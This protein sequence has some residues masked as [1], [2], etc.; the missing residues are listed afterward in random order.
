[1]TTYPTQTDLGLY[2]GLHSNRWETTHLSHGSAPR[3]VTRL[4]HVAHT[5]V[6]QTNNKNINIYMNGA[7][8]IYSLRN[9]QLKKI[10]PKL[11]SQNLSQ[12]Q[13]SFE[14]FHLLAEDCKICTVLIMEFND[15]VRNVNTHQ[16]FIK[17][18]YINAGHVSIQNSICLHSITD[19]TSL[20][21]E[22]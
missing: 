6:T 1:M 21:L 19:Y 11:L 9:I 20:K 16:H 15:H 3:Q 22:T 12:L 13:L 7:R 18:L 10:E 8:H 2:A 5:P 17:N 4:P 14:H